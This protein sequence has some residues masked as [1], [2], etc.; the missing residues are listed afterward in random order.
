M[1]I[2]CPSCQRQ[3]RIP[4]DAVGKQVK[5]PS[6]Q[7]V[8]TPSSAATGE[9]IQAPPAPLPSAPTQIDDAYEDDRLPRRPY[10]RDEDDDE[11]IHAGDHDEAQRRAGAAARWFYIAVAGTLLLFVAGIIL[12]FTA[13]QVAHLPF[14]GPE[15]DLAFV[16]IVFTIAGCGVVHIAIAVFLVIAGIK[17]KSMTGKGWVIAGIV[18]A[19]VQ[20]LLFGVSLLT[21]LILLLTNL[22]EA[23]GKWTP[24]DATFDALAIFV[25]CM[26]AIKAILALQNAAVSAEFERHRPRLWPRPDWQD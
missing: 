3:L 11:P 25:N 21:N 5:C 24:L 4:D 10:E 16:A 19:F 13:G 23:L 8:F 12:A 22:D 7:K 14:A 6:C 9:E 17:L 15:R 18:L 20:A 1:L 26:A 2:F